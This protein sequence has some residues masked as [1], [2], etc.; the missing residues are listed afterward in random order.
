MSY[1]RTEVLPMVRLLDML[2]NIDGEMNIHK[3]LIFLTVARADD[4][5]TQVEVADKVGMSRQTAGKI[6]AQLT[7]TP[8]R[9]TKPGLDWLYYE[10]HPTDSRKTFVKLTEKGKAVLDSM[11]ICME[12]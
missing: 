11:L 7:D 5:I 6:I 1:R 8:L 2:K 10:D 12:T 4:E 3:L 9:G